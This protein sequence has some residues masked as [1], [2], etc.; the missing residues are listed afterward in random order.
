MFLI[1]VKEYIYVS[2]HV[3]KMWKLQFVQMNPHINYTV[4]CLKLIKKKTSSLYI[5]MK[6]GEDILYFITAEF[7]WTSTVMWVTTFHMATIVLSYS[8]FNIYSNQHYSVFSFIMTLFVR[9]LVRVSILFTCGK[10][11]DVLFDNI[12]EYI[13][14]SFKFE[15]FYFSTVPYFISKN[16]PSPIFLEDIFFKRF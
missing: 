13:R 10:Q 15:C 12:F 11:F 8:E 4:V 9:L 14:K 5:L 3:Q 7:A 1:L 2:S 16:S 6:N